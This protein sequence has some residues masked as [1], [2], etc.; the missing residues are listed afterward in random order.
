MINNFSFFILAGGKNSRFLFK[1]KAL[2][3]I[4]GKLILEYE[5]ETLKK[6]SND[7]NI[8][9]SNPD[10]NKFNLPIFADYFS[11][12]GPLGGL[13]AALSNCNTEFVFLLASDM[14]LITEDLL[15]FII[16]SQLPDTIICT[17]SE[18]NLEPLCALYPKSIL[19]SV[20]NLLVSEKLSMH[21]L[22]KQS[23]H[24]IINIKALPFYKDYLFFNMN[25]SED[26]TKL[27]AYL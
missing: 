2:Q 7:I 6:I 8:I 10:F 17:G 14:P 3:E 18:N 25:T 12:K 24:K 27:E 21:N 13:H 19:N 5:L 1:E 9:S 11:Q 4:K 26:L 22:V 23:Q 20:S 16:D 15:N